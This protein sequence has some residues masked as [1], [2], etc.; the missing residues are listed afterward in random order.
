MATV[1]Q[2]HALPGGPRT[3]SPKTAYSPHNPGPV[4]VLSAMAV[5]GGLRTFLAKTPVVVPIG[6]AAPTSSRQ[7]LHG[8][9]KRRVLQWG[10]K[11]K[12]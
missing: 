6:V 11:Y 4:T 1:L 2:P 9:N 12:P 5:P 3:F 8:W 10:G 7:K